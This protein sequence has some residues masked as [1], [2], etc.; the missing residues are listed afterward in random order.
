MEG[1]VENSAVTHL[2]MYLTSDRFEDFDNFEDIY[3]NF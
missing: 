3:P 2:K 1:N